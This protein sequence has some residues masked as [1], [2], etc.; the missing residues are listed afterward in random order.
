M[1]Q[2]TVHDDFNLYKNPTFTFERGLT[3]L[4]GPNGAGKSTLLSYI[5][6]QLKQENIPFFKYDNYTEGG[7]EAKSR[8]GFQ[9]QSELLATAF[10]SSEGEQIMLNYGQIL[11]KLG[12]FVRSHLKKGNKEMYILLDAL[13]S[14]LSINNVREIKNVFK[15]ILGEDT[16]ALIYIIIAVNTYEMISGADCL[17]VKSGK[18]LRFNTY[19]GYADHM[20][21]T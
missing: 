4:V 5:E 6:G 12:T 19:A 13:D 1:K 14:G 7:S 20:C 17:E 9:G 18:H 11:A 2:F 3:C 21:K 16:E 10:C 8:Y 15:L